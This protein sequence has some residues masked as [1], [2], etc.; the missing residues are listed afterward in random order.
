MS[1]TPT[2]LAALTLEHA[3]LAAEVYCENH[4]VPREIVGCSDDELMAWAARPEV[5]DQIGLDEDE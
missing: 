1:T 2:D 4:G 3:K 5:R